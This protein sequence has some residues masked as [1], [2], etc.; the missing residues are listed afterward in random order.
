VRERLERAQQR[1]AHSRG[2]QRVIELD[3]ARALRV[4]LRK[5]ESQEHA[6]ID[7]LIAER[8]RRPP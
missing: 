2:E 5:Q 3:R 7:D 4:T 6:E 1:V 8:A